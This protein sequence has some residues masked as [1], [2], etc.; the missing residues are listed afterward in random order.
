MHKPRPLVDIVAAVSTAL[1]MNEL[2]WVGLIIKP[3]NYPLKGAV[4][5]IDT[6]PGLRIEES[7]MIEIEDYTKAM[8]RGDHTDD[9]GM[10]RQGSSSKLFEQ[11][12]LE[13]S[14]L[15]LPDWTSDI[16][17]VLW[18]PVCAVENRLARGTSAGL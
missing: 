15:T 8:E 16:A 1:L 10:R 11:L 13:D 3:M 5:H 14:K 9:L 17:T 7:R 2:Q 4:L 18:L 6:G 12:K